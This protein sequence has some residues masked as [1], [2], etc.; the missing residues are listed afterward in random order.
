MHSISPEID[1]PYDL[2]FSGLPCKF[3]IM[4]DLPAPDGSQSCKAHFLYCIIIHLRP[5]LLVTPGSSF[6]E[7]MMRKTYSENAEESMDCV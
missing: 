6:C 2:R 3:E 7:I 1:S 5:T 4:L